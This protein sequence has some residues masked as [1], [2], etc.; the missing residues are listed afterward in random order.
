VG[1][2]EGGG[3]CSAISGRAGDV[4]FVPVKKEAGPGRS[5]AKAQWGRRL[6]AGPS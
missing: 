4:G 5:E 6:V 2:E 3:E 1:S